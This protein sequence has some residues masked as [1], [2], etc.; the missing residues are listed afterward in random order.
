MSFA[1]NRCYCQNVPCFC[2]TMSPHTHPSFSLAKFFCALRFCSLLPQWMF[3]MRT[4]IKFWNYWH[5]IS[6]LLDCILL[7]KWINETINWQL[8]FFSHFFLFF[9]REQR[10]SSL[11]I[12]W[13][14][15]HFKSSEWCILW[16]LLGKLLSVYRIHIP[17]Y[18]LES[19]ALYFP[20]TSLM[21]TLIISVPWF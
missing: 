15:V 18:E 12:L 17:Y 3:I 14:S 6:I 7:L 13:N 10:M 1:C 19:I 20:C 9:L 21:K 16:W 2:T 5:L 4:S 8:S 11:L